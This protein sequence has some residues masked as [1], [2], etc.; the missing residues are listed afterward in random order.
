M[1]VPIPSSFLARHGSRG[2]MSLRVR[3]GCCPD[4]RP[5][6]GARSMPTWVSESCKGSLETSRKLYSSVASTQVT[7]LEM[8]S[9]LTKLELVTRLF[10]DSGLQKGLETLEPETEGPWPS[11]SH[12][13]RVSHDPGVGRYNDETVHRTQTE[14]NHPQICTV[15]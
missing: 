10:T 11:R 5:G 7:T 6:A 15:P 1:I 4:T 9:N 13:F 3:A 8:F 12:K 2:D 14:T